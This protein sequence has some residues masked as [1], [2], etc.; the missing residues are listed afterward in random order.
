MI[1]RP[2]AP[3]QMCLYD[4]RTHEARVS[5]FPPNSVRTS[6]NSSENTHLYP[7]SILHVLSLQAVI[8]PPTVF[9]SMLR[10]SSARFNR[11]GLSCIRLSGGLRV[12]AMLAQA[13]ESQ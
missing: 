2:E 9:D 10:S 12:A 11:N 6:V 5:P 13:S 7:P 1:A 8:R 3:L 4:R